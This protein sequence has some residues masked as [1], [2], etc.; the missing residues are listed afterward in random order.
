MGRFTEHSGDTVAGA[1][2]AA[3]AVDPTRPLLTYYDDATG[4]RTELSGATLDNW[5]A[6]TA[7]LLV[8]GCG[9][10]AGDRAA[11]LLPPHWQSAAVL[12]GCWSA[13]LVVEYAHRPPADV[14]QRSPRSRGPLHRRDRRPPGRSAQRRPGSRRRP[15]DRPGRPGARRRGPPSRPAR[16]AARA[17]RGRRLHRP[18]WTPR[19]PGGTEAGRGRAGHRRSLA[20]CSNAANDSGLARAPRAAAVS[21]GVPVRIRFTGTSSFLFD[22]VRGTA[23]TW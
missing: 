19:P 16:L 21:T 20:S 5:A 4:E 9:L 15:R 18:V 8:D 6:K 17:A 11:V 2:A 13:G 1:L 14:A 7:N 22:R 12:L 3:V 10:T 23:G